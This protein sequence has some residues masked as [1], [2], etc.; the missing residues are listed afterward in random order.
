MPA[1]FGRNDV[2]SRQAFAPVE[3]AAAIAAED[4]TPSR[5]VIDRSGQLYSKRVE[6]QSTDIGAPACSWVLGTDMADESFVRVASWGM[7]NA[8]TTGFVART[9]LG[10]RSSARSYSMQFYV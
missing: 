2:V 8:D 9:R 5:T 4:A 1:G 6:P 10:R 3:A 7:R